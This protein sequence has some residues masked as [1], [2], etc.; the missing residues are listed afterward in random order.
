[1]AQKSDTALLAS[2]VPG[3]ASSARCRST[4]SVIVRARWRAAASDTLAPALASYDAALRLKPDHAEALYNRGQAFLVLG[5]FEE[6][7]ASLERALAL[8]PRQADALSLDVESAPGTE[9][10][11]R[12]LRSPVSFL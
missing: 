2:V 1:M 5:R 10:A 6:A 8:R 7:L 3:R 9:L 12:D 4:G 11:D